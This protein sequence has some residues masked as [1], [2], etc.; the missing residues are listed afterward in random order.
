MGDLSSDFFEQ[1]LAATKPTDVL[2]HSWVM[3]ADPATGKSSS[4]SGPLVGVDGRPLLLGQYDPLDVAAA[5]AE[6]YPDYIDPDRFD[7]GILHAISHLEM[8]MF[9]EQLG[10]WIARWMTGPAA[11]C[12]YPD[13]FLKHVVAVSFEAGASAPR[14]VKIPL[15]KGWPS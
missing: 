5:F 11:K 4:C 2:L 7:F 3:G 6:S 9:N 8:L 12:D 1:V 15:T 13:V 14:P 10:Q